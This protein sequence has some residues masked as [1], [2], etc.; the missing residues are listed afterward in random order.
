[1]EIMME[2]DKDEL[3]HLLKYVRMAKGQSEE[4]YEA[5]I[6]I[7]SYGEMDHD[8]MPVVNSKELLADIES[9]RV[10]IEKIEAHLAQV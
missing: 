9:M 1:M 7:E 5:M 3:K 10:I 8:G 6:D 4:L 2:F